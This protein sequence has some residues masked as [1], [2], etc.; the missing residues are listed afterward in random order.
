M[1]DRAREVRAAPSFFDDLERQL[2]SERGP[3]G[4][5]STTDF[6]AFELLNIVERFRTGFDELPLL[7]TGEPTTAS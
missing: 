4:Q 2:R 3:N 7:L 5:P 6:Q 1:S